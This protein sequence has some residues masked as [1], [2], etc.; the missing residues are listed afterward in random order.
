MTVRR[1]WLQA[2]GSDGPLPDALA[3]ALRAECRRT[4]GRPFVLRAYEGDA[5]GA[6][7]ERARWRG[8]G[9]ASAFAEYA[10]DQDLLTRLPTA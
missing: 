7:R 9:N 4:G 6:A 5:P 10:V 3:G 1:C 8:G 2:G